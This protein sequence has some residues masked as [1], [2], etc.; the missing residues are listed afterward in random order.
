MRYTLESSATALRYWHEVYNS[1]LAC[2]YMRLQRTQS[3]LL[4]VERPS[5]EEGGLQTVE[6]IYA[7]GIL[8]AR[9]LRGFSLH[10]FYISSD[11]D[12]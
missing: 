7:S 2:P 8:V 12:S 6:G 3:L 9:T 11:F 4:G 10:A 5:R 1:R